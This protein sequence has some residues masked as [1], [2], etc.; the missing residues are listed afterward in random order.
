MART[1]K[2][3]PA[4]DLMDL[5]ALLPWWVGVAL[6]ADSLKS[7]AYRGT[8]DRETAEWG[9]PSVGQQPGMPGR[10]AGSELGDPVSASAEA[11]QSA[12]TPV[13][14]ERI[15]LDTNLMRSEGDAAEKSRAIPPLEDRFNVKRIELVEKEYHFRDQAGKVA[16]T[17]KFR[18]IST[19]SEIP[20]ATRALVDRAAE[21]GWETVR[22]NGSPEFV[23]QGWIAATAQ[24]L[25]PVATPRPLATEKRPRRSA[26]E[27]RLPKTRGP[28]KGPTKYETTF[29]NKA[30][31]VET[32][33][34]AQ[35]TMSVAG[36]WILHQV[37]GQSIGSP[38][39][40][41]LT[42][43]DRSRAAAIY[44]T[45]GRARTRWP[46]ADTDNISRRFARH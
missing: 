42:E 40:R 29:E 46:V 39:Q 31:A 36:S 25:T 35:D 28:R 11:K 16:F 33:T 44:P 15:D 20:A 6:V 17:D 5:V 27:F 3:G 24:G 10:T 45:V 41:C 37:S 38:T 34:L 14:A 21:R 43:K 12:K 22:L 1:K 13:P 7:E 23:R 2:T 32:L 8:F 30:A 18:S 4:E 9:T 19:A 26:C